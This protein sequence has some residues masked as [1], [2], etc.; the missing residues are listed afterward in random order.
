MITYNRSARCCSSLG[1]LTQLPERPAIVIVD[2]GSSDDTIAAVGAQYPSVRVLEA[3]K[4]LGAAG[5][6]LGVAAAD[7]P[8]RRSL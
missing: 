4:N 5:R 3:G 7:T 2:N 1:R 8:L 6:N